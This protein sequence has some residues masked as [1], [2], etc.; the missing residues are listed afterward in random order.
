MNSNDWI[1]QFAYIFIIIVIAVVGGVACDDVG[2]GG[3]ACY[4]NVC[5]LGACPVIIWVLRGVS[6]DGVCACVCWGRGLW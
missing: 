4:C 3:V 5:I 2:V 1:Q 6:C